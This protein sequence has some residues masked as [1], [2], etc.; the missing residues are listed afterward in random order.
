MKRLSLVFALTLCL[1]PPAVGQMYK[2]V[3]QNG[4]VQ[5]SDKPPPANI[6]SEKLRNAQTAPNPPAPSKDKGGAA[7]DAAKAGPMTLMEQDQAFRKRQQ[8]AAKAEQE[9]AQKQAQA[10]QREENCKRAKLAVAQYQLG[11]RQMR[12]NE[13]GEREY[14]DEK[15]TAQEAERAR[16]DAAAACK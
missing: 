10:R 6:K 1:A 7:K 8:D 16:Q 12:V 3:D 9:A 2:W 13:K 11:G 15:Q 5:Y 4:R 14:L